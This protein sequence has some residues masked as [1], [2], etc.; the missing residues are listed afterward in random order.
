MDVT[1][2]IGSDCDDAAVTFS[3][4]D[5]GMGWSPDQL[6]DACNRATTHSLVLWRELHPEPATT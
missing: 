5:D 3:I 6:T 4:S 2:S 1:I